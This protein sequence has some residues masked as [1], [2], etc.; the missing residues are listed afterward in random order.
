VRYFR[1]L[2]QR[3][4]LRRYSHLRHPRQFALQ[5]RLSQTQITP[6][7]F[8][9]NPKHFRGFFRRQASEETHLDHTRLAQI[10]FFQSVQR[11][12]KIQKDFRMRCAHIR[13]RFERDLRLAAAAFARVPRARVVHQNLPHQLRGNTEKMR[14]IAIIRLV[15]P[16]QPHVGFM[17]QRGRLKSVVGAFAPQIAVC[18]TAQFGVRDR[19]QTVDRI[20]LARFDFAEKLGERTD[21]M[22]RHDNAPILTKLDNTEPQKVASKD[23]E[24]ERN[25]VRTFM[26]SERSA[27]E[28]R[29]KQVEDLFFAAADL[30]ENERTAFLDR[31][32]AEDPELRRETE[33][34]L[35]TESHAHLSIA[36]VIAGAATALFDQASLEGARFGAWQII[37]EIGR[38]GM[39][40]VYLA[41]RA[42]DEF[43]KQ[44]AIKVVKRGIDTD[45]VLKRFRQERRILAVLEHPNIARLLDGGTS[46]DGLPYFVLEYVD[47]KPI[48]TWC[49]ERNLSVAERCEL[50]R[51]VCAPVSFAHRNLVI[52][53]DLKPGN[54]LVT[55]EGEPKLLDFGIAKLLSD[56]PAEHTL[57]FTYD[58]VR[59]LTPA[60]A[61]PEQ[62]RGEPVNTATDVFSLGVVLS[63]ILHGAQAPPAAARNSSGTAEF[64]RVPGG[65]HLRVSSK[66]KLDRDLD[67][68]IMMATRPEPERRYPSVDQLSDDIRR[69]LAGLPVA[70]REDTFG[71][72]LGKFLHR[73]RFGVAAAAAFAALV[74][75][76]VISVAWQA[77]QTEIQRRR[78]EQRLGQLVELA[79]RTL[80]NV[81][82]SIERLPG[83]TEARHEI[84]QTT[85]E[86]LDKLNTES[87]NDTRVLSALVPAYMRLAKIEG[88]PLQPNLGDLHA[89][90]ESYRKAGKIL[91][92]L[93]AADPRNP[94]VLQRQ[95]E[96]GVGFGGLLANTGRSAAAIAQYRRGLTAIAQLLS[97]NP[98]DIELR[99]ISA[100]LHGLL[101]KENVTLDPAAAE[102][103]ALDQLRL[104]TAL[105]V[106]CP[107]DPDCLL[108][109]A[110]DNSLL[111]TLA[112]R[113]GQTRESLAW[114]LKSVALR[115]EAV[116]A[117][118][119][120]V[121]AQRDLMMAY[122]HI[123]D[124]MGS[125]FLFNLGDLKGA[126]EYY[127]KAV[128]IAEAMVATDPSDKQARIDLG[129][130]LTRIGTVLQAPGE[131]AE[132]LAAL[133]RAAGILEP[134]YA[135][136]TKNHSYSVQLSLLYEYRGQRLKQSGDDAAALASYRRSLEIC[137]KMLTIRQD[138]RGALRQQMVDKGAVADLLARA[139][140]REGAIRTAREAVSGAERFVVGRTGSD[141]A[142]VPRSLDWFGAVYE[143]LSD[144]VKASA[145]YRKELL[146]WKALDPA[147]VSLYAR[148]IASAEAALRRCL[149]GR[150]RQ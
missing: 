89:S 128:T 13:H 3:G 136:E 135:S 123:G 34:L 23:K 39:G 26:V 51:K 127:G 120:D 115:E 134:L 60:Y 140:D 144:C 73:N 107:H 63:E 141:L 52:H 17:H 148:D 99:K 150:A 105:L 104:G 24:I 64:S 35:A 7:S 121:T 30:P 25:Q 137:A 106:D 146:A 131:V 9:R 41:A 77:H 129:I 108:L 100:D 130:A 5:K 111:G 92:S 82:G 118:P 46:P 139:G 61:S 84:V 122:G 15:L 114:Y 88:N 59:A 6:D 112:G 54:I 65:D 78:A 66:E 57:G 74:S 93:A 76:G 38:G 80:F 45:A 81:H 87:G 58:P 110:E 32:C 40:A 149:Q 10:L 31:T 86:Y 16:Y 56:Q 133:N 116:A 67:N 69:H 48:H 90:E 2:L 4:V 97:R 49:A 36:R 75:G 8:H 50:F 14:A 98:K 47:G 138:D 96:Y 147:L 55:P 83:A 1:L 70:A 11:L 119:N 132:S 109:L 19:H 125:P 95:A 91:D 124:T 27:A 71:Y 145:T 143:D 126:R 79:N 28:S 68:I 101:D 113:K 94:A 37:R 102:K 18:Q 22:P 21:R 44:V 85:L 62:I 117:R 33:S 43:N 72:R 53:R 20:F 103:D 29:W 12:V 142:Y 42:D